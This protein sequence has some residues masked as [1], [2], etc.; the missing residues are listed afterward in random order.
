MSEDRVR[1]AD[2]LAA[3]LVADQT[4][5]TSGS[6]DVL[7]VRAHDPRGLD[8]LGLRL[9]VL[10]ECGKP[11]AQNA[12]SAEYKQVTVLFADVVRSMDL[13]ATLGPERLRE[14]MAALLDRSTEVVRRYGG[15]VDK[16]SVVNNGYARALVA[17]GYVL[18]LRARLYPPTKDAKLTVV[19]S[20]SNQQACTK[21]VNALKKT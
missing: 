9:H 4:R 16:A 14:L 18:D 11:R 20:A 5:F 13:A 7:G 15:I 2:V 8:G 10:E 21:V 19:F 3:D 6:A 12:Q 17:G 1:L